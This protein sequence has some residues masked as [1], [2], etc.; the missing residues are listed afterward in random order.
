RQLRHGGAGRRRPRDDGRRH[1]SR[2]DEQRHRYRRRRLERLDHAGEGSRRQRRRLGL[3]HRAWDHVGGRQRRAGDQSLAGRA[4]PERDAL[5]RDQL[6]PAERRGCRLGSRQRRGAAVVVSGGVCRRR[7][8]RNGCRG[9]R[10]LVLELRL[11]GRRDRAGDRNHLDRTRRRGCG[12][13]RHGIGHVV[14]VAARGRGGGP[15]VGPASGVEPGAGCRAD[16]ARVGSRPARARP[17]LRPRARR[18]IRSSWAATQAPAAQPAGEANEPNGAPKR[19]TPIA[20][21]AAGTISPEGDEDV[22]AVDVAGPKWF[23]ATVTPPPLSQTVRASEVDPLVEALGPK[24]ERLARAVDNTVGRHESALV[25]AAS[26]GRYYVDVK[27]QASS[28]GS[29]SIPVADARAPA[30]FDG[31]QWRGFP[32]VTDLRNVAAA[33]ITGDGRKDVV[34]TA[35][36]DTTNPYKLMVLPQRATG[37]LGD[38]TSF[39]VDIGWAI[40][41]QTGDLN[42]DGSI[43]VVVS[44]MAGPEIFYNRGGSLADRTVLSQPTVP[45]GLAAAGLA[46]R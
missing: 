2:R 30:L 40:G 8:R 18:C 13:I 32:D 19:A 26:A 11:L 4:G 29:Y 15:R 33:D 21:S 17:V 22:F 3:R 10:R 45:R 20:G 12:R 6:C 14:R 34:T 5:R 25:P 46:G 16:P 43:D 1:R 7:G 31:E 42:G 41:L 28:R 39:S 23:S 35:V 38:A 27:S 9:R 44:T 24:G 36:D 37:G